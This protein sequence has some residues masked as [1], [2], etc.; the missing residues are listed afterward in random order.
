MSVN[1][2]PNIYREQLSSEYQGLALWD[3]KPVENLF[4]KPPHVSIGDVGYLDRGAFIRIFNVKLSRDE[5]SST[6]IEIPEGYKPL[7]Q[8]HFNNIRRSE[9]PQE[10]YCS[11]VSKVDNRRANTYDE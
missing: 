9:V 11:H 4:E 7:K 6:L 10:E 3:P 8:E 2:P 5:Q 1:R